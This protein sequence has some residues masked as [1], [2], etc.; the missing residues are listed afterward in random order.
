MNVYDSNMKEE[1]NFDSG[2]F[3]IN[4]ENGFCIIKYVS[5]RF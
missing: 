3:F 2:L 4:I 1:V 5:I